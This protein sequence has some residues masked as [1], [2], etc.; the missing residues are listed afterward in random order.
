MP[1]GQ[2]SGKAAPRAESRVRRPAEE[3]TL[4]EARGAPWK[5]SVRRGG[6][7]RLRPGIPRRRQSQ[8]R[9]GAPVQALGVLS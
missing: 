5:R 4:S 1:L 3:I 9:T 2:C 8:P 7:Q 6:V